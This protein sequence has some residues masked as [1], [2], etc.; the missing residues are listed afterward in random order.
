MGGPL[1]ARLE[2]TLKENDLLATQDA[3]G[4][5]RL[6]ELCAPTP[7]VLVPRFEL[8]VHDLKS[9][10]ET[11]RYLWGEAQVDAAKATR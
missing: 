5:E 11:S 8:D 9:V 7:L 3:R 1:Q 2:Q 4:I 10:W 6:R